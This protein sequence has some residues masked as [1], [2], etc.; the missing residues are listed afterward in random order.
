M[1]ERLD[2]VRLEPG[3]I[4]DLG[5]GTGADLN[6][7]GERY[8]KA[9]RIACDFVL[10]MLKKVRERSAWFKRFLL[11]G[12]LP[13]LLCADAEAL[14]LASGSASLIWSNLCCNGSPIPCPRSKR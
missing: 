13:Q 3:Y 6:F 11:S 10:P 14:P 5:C 9:R 7:L 4:L 12:S 8:P 1:G 2:Y